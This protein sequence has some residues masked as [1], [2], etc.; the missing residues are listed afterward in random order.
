MNFCQFNLSTDL[1]K[2]KRLRSAGVLGALLVAAALIMP[3][4]SVAAGLPDFTDLIEKNSPA[5]VKINTID[6]VSSNLRRQELPPNMPDIF[7]DFF[8][9][10]PSPERKSQAIG[11]GFIISQDGYIL[12]NNHVVDGA[13]EIQVRLNDR[14]EFAAEVVGVDRR[15]DL[16]LLKVDAE[17][18]PSVKFAKS[19]DLRV[20][21]W[22]VAIGSPFG[23]DYSASAGIVSAIGRSIPTERGEDY[24]PFIQ[25][26]VA[27]NPGNSGGP[28]FN[29]KGEVVGINSQIYT[30]SG[31]SIGL[32]FAIP[33]SVALEVVDQLKD[34]GR[35]E[36]GW[37]GVYIQDV[38][39]DLAKSLGLSKPQG[40]LIAQVE[41][42][43]PADKAGMKPGD[44]VIKLNGRSIVDASDLPHTV[45]LIKPGTTVAGTLIRNGQRREVSVKVDVR[46]GDEDSTSAQADQD[47]LG[48]E[49]VEIEERIKDNWRLPGGVMVRTVLP[50]TPAERAGLQPGD[51]LVQLGYQVI[52]NL[53]DYDQVLEKLPS[54]TPVAL[55]FFRRGRSIFRTIE[56]D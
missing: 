13:D 38:D 2:N 9:Q 30:R 22:V 20:G 49:V 25:T 54:N 31:G 37:L 8:Q 19:D 34:K 12:T 5:V 15:S 44:V 11:S 47:R 42:N 28:L 6:K 39:K 32:S 23:L 48:L 24:V 43:S 10:R 3:A 55:R 29:L 51:V 35:V 41:E 18:L 33:V 17:D 14:Q 40:A 1:V 27:I 52:N 16:A 4:L 26:D 7:R 56:L 50:E 53:S 46:P 36:R 21:E 45:G